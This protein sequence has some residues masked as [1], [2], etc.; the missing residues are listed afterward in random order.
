M[1][2]HKALCF[3]R[4]RYALPNGDND[5]VYNQ[6][7]VIKA[8]IEKALSPSIITNY[9]SILDAVSGA[10]E[11]NMDS[12]DIMK[13][14][15]AQLQD[16]SGYTF[17]SQQLSG[18]GDTRYGGAYYPYEPLYYMIPDENSVEQCKQ[19]IKQMT[20]SSN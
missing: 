2:G 17:H 18:W 7:L 10:I 1:D 14:I 5:R 6:Q 3:V 8:M 9:T 13:F 11:L 12:K 20:Y 19:M 15:R 4:E 16:M